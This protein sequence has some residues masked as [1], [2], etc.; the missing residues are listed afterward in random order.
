MTTDA[1]P[2]TVPFR[3][4]S[5]AMAEELDLPIVLPSGAF[6]ADPQIAWLLERVEDWHIFAR[7]RRLRGEAEAQA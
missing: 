1:D 2:R 5:R 7:L 4:V 6:V 3:E